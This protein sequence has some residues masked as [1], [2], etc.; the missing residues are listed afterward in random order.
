[1]IYAHDFCGT[2]SVQHCIND[3]Q[4]IRSCATQCHSQCD[5]IELYDYQNIKEGGGWTKRADEIETPQ[6]AQGQ[7]ITSRG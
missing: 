4:M 3:I 7:P 2:T 1:M 6:K 5:R